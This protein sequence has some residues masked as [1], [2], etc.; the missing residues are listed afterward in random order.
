MSSLSFVNC[1]YHHWQY[2]IFTTDSTLVSSMADEETMRVWAHSRAGLPSDVLALST[3]PKP[4]ITSPTHV[5]VKI[6]HCALN[7][8]G[9]IVMQLLPFMFRATPA[10]PE[11]DFSG[12]VVEAGPDV[13]S[14][15]GLKSNAEVF[16]SIPLAQ[17]VK[18]TSG[19][20]AEYVVVDHTALVVKPESISM[21]AASGLGIAGATALQ[22]IKAANLRSGNLVLVNGSGGGIGHLVVQMC[23]EKVGPSGQVV[24][25]CSKRSMGWIKA[26]DTITL[27]INDQADMSRTL[28]SRFHIIDREE[29]PLV[30]YLTDIFGNKR[31]DAIIDAVGIQE[32]YTAS[33]AF[34]AE[35]KPYVTVGPRA[36]SYTYLDMLSTLGT[37]ARNMLWPRVLGGVARPYFQVAAASSLETLEKLADMVRM[38]NLGVY[39]GMK[40]AW[41]DAAKVSMMLF[42][43]RG[44]LTT[45]RPM[46]NC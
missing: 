15:R 13:P 10:I 38:N 30:Q 1:S 35:G 7:P 16:G 42:C 3:L 22:L 5:L 28:M 29:Q 24:A 17:I 46:R 19:A 21:K 14:H 45:D 40:V 31:F 33:P 8:G 20:L 39:V 34:L 18:S 12:T 23:C 27:Q 41:S 44:A 6:S 9:S 4:K 37:M 11:M 25:I 2:S 43:F 36:A 32:I 26:L